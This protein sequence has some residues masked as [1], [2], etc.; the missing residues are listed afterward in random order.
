MNYHLFEK[1]FR[2]FPIFSV[3][4]IRKR[5]FEMDNRRLV[6]WQ[7]KGYLLKIKRG[8]YCFS[9]KEKN[10][11]FLH[12]TANKIYS[13][14]YISM[15]SGLSFY[16]MIPEGVFSITSVTTRNT[17]TYE[18]PLCNFVYRNIKA[19]LFFGYK[20]IR[21][22]EFTYKI[23]EPEKVLLDFLYLN[24]INSVENMKE[25]RLNSEIINEIIDKDKLDEYLAI[26]KSLVL[27]KRVSLLKKIHYA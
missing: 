26:F 19:S 1:A 21:T 25:L 4:D 9:E 20:L 16:Q 3:K 12:I 18:T 8:Y 2:E 7:Q 11:N 15:E 10:N 23:A 13:P 24:T 14:S 5:F 27:E 22:E 6:E 17:A